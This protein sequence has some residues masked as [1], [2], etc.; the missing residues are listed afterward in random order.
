MNKKTTF[1]T[2]KEYGRPIKPLKK[3]DILYGEP[4]RKGRYEVIKERET[5]TVDLKQLKT[6]RIFTFMA[7]GQF[8]GLKVR[9][10]E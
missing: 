7:Q 2:D 3:G 4:A 5:G 1:K 8:R 9:R 6:G 10:K